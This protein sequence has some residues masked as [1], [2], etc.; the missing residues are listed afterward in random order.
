MLKVALI[1]VSIATAAAPLA[2]MV[3]T[4]DGTV[5][6]SCPH[7]AMKTTN[8]DARK[9][10]IPILYLRICNLSSNLGATV[11]KARTFIG[12]MRNDDTDYP[13][14]INKKSILGLYKMAHSCESI[15]RLLAQRHI[16]LVRGCEP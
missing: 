12:L 1:A 2:G 11:S 3:D 15:L 9:H 13:S 16:L 7:P 14:K 10:V 5:T 8:R 4:T 6:V